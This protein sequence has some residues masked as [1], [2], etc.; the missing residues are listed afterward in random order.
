MAISVVQAN[1]RGTQTSSAFA[2]QFLSVVTPGNSVLLGVAT[3]ASSNVA[4][5]SANPVAGGSPVAAA[6]KLAEVQSAWNGSFT[7]YVAIWLLPDLAGGSATCGVTV[8]NGTLNNSQTGMLGWEVAGLGASPALDVSSTG[9]GASTSATSGT[10]GATT[11]AAEIVL[12]VL[13]GLDGLT[14][15]PASP[16]SY[17]N[18]NIGINQSASCGGYQ[19]QSSPGGTYTYANANGGPDPWAGVI[20][21]VYA[22]SGAAHTATAALTAT[23]SFTA[24]R[25]RGHPRTGTLTVTPSFMAHFTGL[26]SRSATLTVTPSFRVST[27]NLALPGAAVPGAAIPGA[28]DPGLPRGPVAGLTRTPVVFGL[29]V[30]CFR[31][32]AGSPY[33]S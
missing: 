17:A 8:T 9:S 27:V 3:F 11:Q 32:A 6:S 22:G 23:P 4:I 7:A 31:W 2:V 26:Q 33:L 24:T 15:T 13:V 20:V 21:T 16:A 25:T 30:P 1:Q 14:G 12:G 19:V 29:G 5:S 10:T 28:A 18:Q